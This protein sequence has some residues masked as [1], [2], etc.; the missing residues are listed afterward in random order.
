[1]N[2]IF[3]PLCL[4]LSLTALTGCGLQ[5][6]DT[7]KDEQT[8]VER[9]AEAPAAT[10]GYDD[11]R[12]AA[13][14]EASVSDG[15]LSLKLPDGMTQEMLG[16]RTPEMIAVQVML[17]HTAHAPGVIDGFGGGN[18]DSAIRYF[19]EAH[20]MSADGGVDD[21]LL[22]ALFDETSGDIFRT[23]TV[24]EKDAK[25][26]FKKLPEDFADMAEMDA[27]GYE[28]P[29]E[30]L[31]ERFHMDAE[32]LQALNPDADFGKAGTKLVIV[33]HGNEKVAGDIAKLE[34][35][36]GE[37]RLVAF[38]DAGEIVASFPASI[39][40]V[41]F[42]SPSGSM[43]VNTVAPEP[44]YT[45][46]GDKQE[47]GPDG[48]FILPPGPNNPVGGTWIDLTK[49][50]YGIHGTPDPDFIAKGKSHGCVRLT[51]WNAAALAKVIEKGTK[52][53]F[54]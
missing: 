8:P 24:T 45:F 20:G 18:T 22:Q 44:N 32:F 28:T 1:M 49:D 36:K 23:Y 21:K 25:G 54:A 51:N 48:T 35:R 46:D 34:V 7:D 30:M 41:E 40:S 15:K 6:T 4:A 53:V 2:R 52:V 11:P 3:S 27:L 47:W 38:D 19:R 5:G 39:G 10:G 31:A 43:S 37:G 26:P 17:D 50:G 42:P 16:D 13:E 29:L 9:K 14:P 12:M 33:S